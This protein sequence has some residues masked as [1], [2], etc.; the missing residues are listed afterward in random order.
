MYIVRVK[1]AP[2]RYVRLIFKALAEAQQAS[3]VIQACG[4]QVLNN[5][6]GSVK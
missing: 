4:R 6:S 5:F 2:G 1:T 3:S